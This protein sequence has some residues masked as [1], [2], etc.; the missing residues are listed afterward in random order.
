MTKTLDTEMLRGII[1]DYIDLLTQ[2]PLSDNLTDKKLADARL[3]LDEIGQD[4][5]DITIEEITE[6]YEVRLRLSQITAW[7]KHVE[8]IGKDGEKVKGRLRWDEN[9]GYEMFWDD[10][11]PVGLMELAH[12]PEFEYTLDS[13]TN[14][15]SRGYIVEG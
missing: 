7:C 11:P 8:F 12:R 15:D 3:L 1:L 5:N 4:M 14:G 9:T 6:H 10:V 13:Y 2:N